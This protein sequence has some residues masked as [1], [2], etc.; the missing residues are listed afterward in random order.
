MVV[1]LGIS[2][3]VRNRGLFRRLKE[4]TVQTMAK[5]RETY[6]QTINFR[7]H[8]WAFKSICLVSDNDKAG[9]KHC[10]I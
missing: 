3:V 10:T 8:D 9:G 1:I 6:K 7:W 2:A 5:A 4:G